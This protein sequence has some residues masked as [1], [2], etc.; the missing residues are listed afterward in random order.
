M[1]F[2]Q[3]MEHAH[4][5]KFKA[6]TESPYVDQEA[7]YGH[8]P[9][10]YQ[11]FA[12]MPDPSAFD[13]MI[14]QLAVALNRLARGDSPKDPINGTPCFANPTL[15]ELSA[16][17]PWLARWTGEAAAAFKTNFVDPF[18]SVVANQF[19]LTSMLKSA[20]EA[21]RELWVN[22]RADIDKI[23]HDTIAALEQVDECS[24]SEWTM[25]FTVTAAVARSPATEGQAA[26]NGGPVTAE[27]PTPCGQHDETPAIDQDPELI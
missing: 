4:E 13:P 19:I 3:L 27:H 6:W 12:E 14:E 21:E 26:R 8:V 7:Y 2:G 9:G 15:D 20:L 5:I 17:D 25:T 24:T 1:S 16:T 10:L 23:A 11:P 18:P 22:A